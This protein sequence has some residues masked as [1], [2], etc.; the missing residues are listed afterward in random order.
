MSSQP[1]SFRWRTIVEVTVISIVIYVFLGTPGLP[2]SSTNESQVY[3]DVPVARAKVES[4]VYPD[5]DLRC[6]KHEF[7]VHIFSTSPLVVYID[8]FLNEAEADH[9]VEIR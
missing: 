4:L 7:D 8:G 2:S 9:L 1:A 3:N 5:K 6:P